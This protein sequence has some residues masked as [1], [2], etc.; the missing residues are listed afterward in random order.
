MAKDPQVYLQ[1]ILESIEQIE[2][3]T[4]DMLE[5]EFMDS[6][7]KQ[8]AVLRRLEIIGEAAK[9]I[10]QSYRE[11]HPEIPWRKIAGMRDNLIHEYF[12]VD[13]AIVWD[14]VKESV[15]E[16]KEQLTGLLE[17]F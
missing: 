7:E 6:P 11:K 14:T 1:H 12:A 2:D 16:L 13:L 5:V 17:G 10:P 4:R 9:N 3:Y 15:P 8:D